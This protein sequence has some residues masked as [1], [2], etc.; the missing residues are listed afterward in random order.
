M[1]YHH[2]MATADQHRTA[3]G[4]IIELTVLLHKDM[5]VSLGRLGMTESRAHLLWELRH[6]GPSTQRVLAEAMNVSPRNITGLVDAL[7]TTGFVTREQHPTDR[8]AA[9]VSFTEAGLRT[10]EAMEQDQEKAGH[11]LFGALTDEQLQCFASGMDI[12]LAA[13]RE[14]AISEDD[15]DAR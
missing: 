14:H 2:D 15:E 5:A 1:K 9:L 13:L 3:Y 6:R 12:V 4:Q 11:L 8:R 10:V 7:V